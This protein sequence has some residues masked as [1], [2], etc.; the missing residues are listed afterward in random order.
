MFIGLVLLVPSIWSNPVSSNMKII[1]QIK[2]G[3]EDQNTMVVKANETIV[4][5]ETSQYYM[6]FDYREREKFIQYLDLHSKLCD[7]VLNAGISYSRTTAQMR[8]SGSIR[9]IFNFNGNADKAV[10]RMNI[11]NVESGN[12]KYID[13][14]KDEMQE[15]KSLLK[16][17][18][19]DRDELASKI[20]DLNS[21]VDEIR[22]L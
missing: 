5:V 12:Y 13:L 7:A 10:L 19:I 4:I 8:D 15:L 14:D 21:I 2:Y 17:A 9:I 16:N 11:S 20:S 1:G 3:F 6:I 18:V 22:S